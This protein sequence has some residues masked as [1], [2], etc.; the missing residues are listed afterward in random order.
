MKTQG[1]A[2][3]FQNLVD[4]FKE[5]GFNQY[6]AA[7]KAVWADDRIHSLVSRMETLQQLRENA[8]AARRPSMGFM[9]RRLLQEYATAT[10]HLYCRGC[11]HLCEGCLSTRV[12]IADTLRYRMYHEYYGAREE[13][14]QLFSLLPAEARAFAGVDFSTAESACPYGVPIGALMRDAA[15]KLA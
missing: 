1:G 3:S 10:D 13:A 4:P 8:E 2:I 12:R 7:L 9:E 15:Q 14:R 11:A 6:Q 5:K